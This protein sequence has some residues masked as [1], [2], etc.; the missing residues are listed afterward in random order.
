M[1]PSGY[2]EQPACNAY[3]DAIETEKSSLPDF[4]CPPVSVDGIKIAGTPD[5][6]QW[7][8]SEPKNYSSSA[9]K[10]GGKFYAYLNDIPNTFRYA[11]PGANDETV[12]L[13][14][15]QMPFLWTSQETFEFMPCSA[16]HWAVNLPEN[17]VYYK[18]SEKI[19]W[20]DGT[21][22]TAD[23][24]LFAN[25]FLRSKNIVDPVQNYRA[26]NLLVKKIGDFCV[27]VT[28]TGGQH[29]TEYELLD[30]TNFKPIAKHFYGGEIPE[31]WPEKYN[32]IVE[33]TTGPYVLAEYDYNNGLKFVKVKDWWAQSYPHFMGIA[34]FDE[35][36]YRIIAGKKGPAFR[37]FALGLFDVI[38]L[39]NP[40]EWAEAV[41]S[42]NVQ[43]GFVNL[44]QG[45]Y[46]PVNGPAGLFFNTRA[47]PLDNVFV[48]KGLYYAVDMDG[49]IATAYLGQRKRLH[50]LGVGQIWGAAEFNNSEIKK[51]AFNPKKAMELF[52]RAGYKNL[53]SKGILV[54]EEGAE[55]TFTVLFKEEKE[56]ELFG[57]LYTQ[58]LQAGVRLDFKYYPGGLISKVASRDYQAWWGAMP[59]LQIPNNYTFLHSSFADKK[60]FENFFG[61]ADPELDSLLEKFND[62]NL[63]YFEK[64]AINRQIEKIADEA[65]LMIPSYYKNTISVMAWKWLCFPVWLNMRYQDRLDEPMFGYIWFDGDIEAECK[66]AKAENKMLED[67]SYSLS[68]RYK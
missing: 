54:N 16:T 24:W 20:S 64:A 21:A 47:K 17:T 40:A 7:Y 6:L 1:P 36:Y 62:D 22:C 10:K 5:Y 8:T 27:S 45:F 34:N 42:V 18:L 60:T 61:Y 48:R 39:D 58:A 63:T 29:Y 46:V 32:R 15:T 52:A 41:D 25:K 13:F 33:P 30:I 51:P 49:L 68:E 2:L 14:N 55:L 23:D 67:A 37:K 50:T 31:N 28:Y 59:N 44:W 53:N 43:E 57:F 65:A 12:K 3:A 38:H 19:R 66:R 4:S 26:D 56:R 9:L 11:G 35:I